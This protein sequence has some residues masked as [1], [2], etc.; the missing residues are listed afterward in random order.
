MSAPTSIDVQ[1]ANKALARRWF[2]EGWELGNV[3]IAEEIFDRDLMLRGRRVGPEGP[4]RSVLHRR[5]AFADMTV[6]I[7]LQVAEGDT[8]VTH[9]TTRARHVGDF[10][11]VPPTGRVVTATGIVIWRIR[12]GRVVEDRNT[13][14]RWAVIS[15]IDPV[16]THARAG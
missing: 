11:G 8:V 4:R 5:T 2:R 16:M 3:A 9:F 7:D 12:H 15:Q 6:H 13:F 14:D 1:E 10:C